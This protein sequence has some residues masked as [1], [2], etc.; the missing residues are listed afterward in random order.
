ME[1]HGYSNNILSKNEISL[2][3]SI[4]NNNFNDSSESL[5]DTEKESSEEIELNDMNNGENTECSEEIEPNNSQNIEGIFSSLNYKKNSNLKSCFLYLADVLLSIFVFSPLVAFYWYSTWTLL[6]LHFIPNNKNLSNILSS[7]IGLLIILLCYVFAKRLFNLY[8]YFRTQHTKWAR[9]SLFG[10]RVIYVYVMGLAIIFQWR[11]LWNLFD[12][13]YF[14][15]TRSQISL[16]ILALT[17]F[18]LTRSTRCLIVTPFGLFVD[19]V[20]KFFDTD[21]ESRHR[22]KWVI[23]IFS[24]F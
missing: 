6:D 3:N 4:K 20:D 17:Y 12:A 10:M 22:V 18:C 16:S 24:L 2:I 23:K 14:E 5:V 8:S 9:I 7:L 11:G 19:D 1:A 15:D 21:N 13:Y